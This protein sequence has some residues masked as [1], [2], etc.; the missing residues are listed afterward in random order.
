[1]YC[2]YNV[3]AYLQHVYDI[4]VLLPVHLVTIFV[5]N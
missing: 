1:M 2:I 4:Y 5:N 3:R